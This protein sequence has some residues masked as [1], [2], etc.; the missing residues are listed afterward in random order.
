MQCVHVCRIFTKGLRKRIVQ[1][2]SKPKKVQQHLDPIGIL[3][4]LSA[5]L[6]AYRLCITVEGRDLK[7][8]N[9]PSVRCLVNRHHAFQYNLE[10]CLHMLAHLLVFLA[11]QLCVTVGDI[12][13]QLRGTDTQSVPQMQHH[14]FMT[15]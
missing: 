10:N 12:D 3:L 9:R 2:S 11:A 6:T 14:F 5:I 7:R 8:P 1:D 4:Q 15:S 13:V